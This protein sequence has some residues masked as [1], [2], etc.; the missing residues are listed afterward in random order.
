M[1][2]SFW[3]WFAGHIDG[4]GCVAVYDNMPRISITKA[5]KG[6]PAIDK[7]Q[8]MLGGDVFETPSKNA[9]HQD[10]LVWVLRSDK[11]AQVIARLIMPRKY[12]QVSN[13]EPQ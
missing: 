3:L 9:K 10:M 1:D 13:E 4:D 11:A 5:I 12:S 8:A 2:P 6:K 7:I